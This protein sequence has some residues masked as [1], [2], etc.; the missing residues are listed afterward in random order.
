MVGSY[1]AAP[2]VEEASSRSGSGSSAA[3]LR[4][5]SSLFIEAMVRAESEMA[6][7]WR[8]PKTARYVAL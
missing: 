8:S 1:E 2:G 5:F 3:P 7:R 6:R 4:A